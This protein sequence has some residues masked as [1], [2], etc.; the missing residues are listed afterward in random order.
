MSNN[1]R[2]LD[3]VDFQGPP[4]FIVE[5]GRI[6]MKM[7]TLCFL[8]LLSVL[9]AG[10]SYAQ[11]ARMDSLKNDSLKRDLPKKD[12]PEKDSPRSD[13][14]K[15]TSSRSQSDFSAS[16]FADGAED[17]LVFNIKPELFKPDSSGTSCAYM[18]TYRVKRQARGSDTVFPA[19]YTTCVPMQ[20]FE[21]RSAV[22]TTTDSGAGE[23]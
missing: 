10:V 15:A 22:E 2:A 18:R 20:R 1:P 14:S 5:L 6:S 21:M 16:H 13:S 17:R 23:K 7:M 11:D 4:A 3:Y 19:G 8:L 12:S 9:L